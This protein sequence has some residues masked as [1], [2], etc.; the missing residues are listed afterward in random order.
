MFLMKASE[1]SNGIN[2]YV[3]GIGSSKRFVMWDTTTDRM[4]DDEIMFIFGHESGHYVLNHIPKMLAGLMVG[5]FF[6]FWAC[7]NLAEGMVRRF[8]ERWNVHAVGKPRRIPDAL[9]RAFNCRI[10]AYASR[11]H[12]QPPL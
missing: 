12:R 4:P 3:T 7:A 9:L 11:Q 8:G 5:L 1:K 6:V 10:R 2:A